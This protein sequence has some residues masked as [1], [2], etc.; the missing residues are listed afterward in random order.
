MVRKIISSYIYLSFILILILIYA[1][2]SDYKGTDP[3]NSSPVVYLYDTTDSTSSKKTTIKWYGNDTDGIKLKYFYTVTTDTFINEAS[4][5]NIL[6]LEKWTS[7][8]E[9]YANVSMPYYNYNADTCFMDLRDYGEFVTETG[10]TVHVT[11]KAVYSKFFVAG[12]DEAG[13][14]TPVKSKIFKRTNVRPKHPMVYSDKLGVN[15]FDKY[16]ITVGTDSAQ[17][18]MPEP[19]E[20]WKEIDFKWMGE[21]PDGSDVELEFK[22]NLLELRE[23]LKPDTLISSRDWSREN[24]SASFSGTIYNNNKNGRYSFR[25]WVRDDAYEQSEYNSTINF[26]VFAPT[27]DK[28]I[29]FIDDTDPTLYPPPAYSQWM[30]NP[31]A[32]KVTEFYKGMLEYS[33]YKPG[34]DNSVDSLHWYKIARFEKKVSESGRTYYSPNIRELIKYR[35]VILS[36]EDRSTYN[37]I[38]FN[39]E[40]GYAGYRIA[41]KNY[42]DVGGKVFI[43]GPSVL[44]GEKY[45]Q[46]P[47]QLPVN[48]YKKPYRQI[49]EKDIQDNVNVNVADPATNTDL[50]IFFSQYFG[51]EFMDFPEYKTYYTIPGTDSTQFCADHYMA[52]NY[53]FIGAELYDH[54]PDIPV[55]ALRIDSTK[56]N[57][58]WLNSP[59]GSGGR[60]RQHALK[61]RGTV[62]TGVPVLE[63]YKGEILYSYRSIYDLP[64]LSYNQNY[65]FDYPWEN[66]A[67]TLKHSLV[68]TNRVTGETAGQVL[69]RSGSVAIRYIEENELFRTAFFTM[70]LYFMDNSKNQVSEMFKAMIDWFKLEK[71]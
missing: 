50:R 9:T 12:M 15:G 53:D 38:N 6:P 69:E 29:L 67:D 24:L 46:I 47:S 51:I 55:N 19:N 52:D 30:G 1:C 39:G 13:R 60:I 26:E 22:W 64:R 10:D 42:L 21:D 68:L 57:K 20:F 62:F 37:G 40:T 14:M 33:G 31:E 4:A 59:P 66:E 71:K 5:L 27:F 63:A 36:S 44:Q 41:L 45:N 56:V 65:T 11:F 49:F 7:T 25:V 43:V 32:A 17:L 58:T 18:I 48:M 16:W 35:L 2:S 28:G 70:P 54:V 23:P 61:D 8:F 3:G 34:G